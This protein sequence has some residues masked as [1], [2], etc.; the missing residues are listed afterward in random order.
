M[1][2]SGAYLRSA[3]GRV[4]ITTD[5]ITFP[6]Q[7]KYGQNTEF[8]KF[9]VLAYIKLLDDSP[10]NTSRTYKPVKTYRRFLTELT[11]GHISA[12]IKRYS[13]YSHEILSNEYTTGVDAST[14]VF[15]EFMRD[16]PITYEYIVWLKTGRP[17]LMRYI[18][19]FLL[20]G[21]K[22][23]YVDPEFDAT[24]LRGWLE[25][26]D[27]LRT[28]EFTKNDIGSL[29]NIVSVILPSLKIDGLWPKFGPGK[30]AERDVRDV[31]DKLSSLQLHP[32]LGY[33]FN[34]ERPKRSRQEG[35]GC[36]PAIKKSGEH[37]G[38]I[39]RLKFVPKD[40][41]KSRSI[42]M[43]PNAFMY[44]Q[45]EVHRWLRASIESG[46]IG[47]F[48]DIEDQVRSQMA[49]VHGSIYL[50]TDTIDLS[51]A[52][53]SV[54][55][56][57]VRGIFPK[58]ILFYLLATRTSK[59]ELPDG[60]CVTVKKFAPMGSACCFPVQCIVFTAVC[61]YAAI[62]V[63]LG[64]ETGDR[65]IT[66]SEVVRFLKT[67]LHR[68]RGPFTPFTKR[69]E[70]PVVYGDDIAVDSRT[71]GSVVTTLNRLGFTVN[72]SKS[73]TGSQTFRESCGV[74]A[75]D[76]QDIT[77]VQFRLPF[78]KR[79]NWD[80]KVYSSF[81]GAI[82]WA[83]DNGFQSLASFYLAA[84][85]GYRFKYRLPFTT[86]RASFG[87]YTKNKHRVPTE[88]RKWDAAC[89]KGQGPWQ[90]EYEC[91]QGIGPKRP[92][93]RVDPDNLEE[94]RYDQWWRCRVRGYTPLEQSRSLRIR[95]Q[96]TRLAP[97]WARCE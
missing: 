90:T 72:R 73:F 11:S 23:E 37:S 65:I 60:S 45:Q 79:G 77:P 7:L 52:S 69:F 54:H 13:G 35:F 55:V 2:Y 76:G 41:T 28:L 57:L 59:V 4:C 67:G 43:E 31:F 17:D 6:P 91:V 9:F 30:V 12:L 78:F 80:A 39:G 40:I 36:L 32:R 94:Y 63:S 49:A 47:R 18:Q 21:K 24:A 62:A 34:R 66:T 29:G 96:E 10:L 83:N 3:G 19:T 15:H 88:S 64:E 50:S 95:P 25:V 46:P 81:I 48:V 74:F 33:A 93:K 53:D 26:E 75:F 38:D 42:C 20:F 68:E 89:P 71:T 8:L 84:L 87:I 70:P 82:N 44:F 85:R 16:T 27:K 14:R 86:D 5:D 51:S 56:D 1:P 58:E 61:I 92:M 22:I 97:Q